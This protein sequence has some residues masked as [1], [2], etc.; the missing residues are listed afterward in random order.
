[1]INSLFINIL[2]NDKGILRSKWKFCK[3]DC[4]TYRYNNKN[5]SIHSVRIHNANKN[6]SALLYSVCERQLLMGIGDCNWM[7]ISP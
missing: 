1:M 7:L 4:G 6:N 3:S 2:I 5:L